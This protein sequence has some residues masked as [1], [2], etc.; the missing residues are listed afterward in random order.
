[1][2]MTPPELVKQMSVPVSPS[3][4]LEPQHKTKKDEK[5][6]NQKLVWEDQTEE[7]L[8]AWSDEAAC[9]KWMHDQAFRKYDS[10][11]FGVSVPIFIFSTI[12]GTVS[13]AMP[14]LVPAEYIDL[15]QKIVGGVNIIVGILNAFQSN[16]KW[17][18]KSESHKQAAAGW[19]K[20]ERN[21][22]IELKIPRV[23]RK[24]ADLFHKICRNEY[25]RLLEQSPTITDDII[26]RF[27]AAF[28]NNPQL[29][30]PDI[31][32][33]LQHT[34]ITKP[35]EEPEEESI[36]MVVEIKQP[37]A[38]HEQVLKEIKEI[39]AESRIVPVGVKDAEI[40]HHYHHH[41][42]SNGGRKN[43]YQQNTFMGFPPTENVEIELMP[44]KSFL[45]TPPPII[46]VKKDN[47]VSMPSVKELA[48]RFQ[49]R[50]SVISIENPL[51]EPLVEVEQ[52]TTQSL[53][54]PLSSSTSSSSSAIPASTGTII[55]SIVP[56]T[57][58]TQENT[59]EVIEISVIETAQNTPTSSLP[60]TPRQP[61]V[62][63]DL[64]AIQVQQS[65]SPPSS[66]NE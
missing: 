16:E 49:V 32:D 59:T 55:G 58:N 26:E 4:L 39:L 7:M 28:K 23:K 65:I 3:D 10:I 35:E 53:F 45:G 42:N 66:S 37:P 29:V 22:R 21:I 51:V 18:Q 50:N 25:D 30:K 56:S 6:N 57:S 36:P 47:K 24:D 13:V 64:S 54:Q 2:S 31:C 12:S 41:V 62:P 38:P 20:L 33:N 15:A 5:N 48:K 40:G 46:N 9:Y 11:N 61:I 34:E 63:I 27:K 17:A 19:G 44:R 1:M 60:T 52:P 8:A 14:S 43:T